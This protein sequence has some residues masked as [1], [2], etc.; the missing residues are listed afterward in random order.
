ML[1]RSDEEGCGAVV[2]AAHFSITLD[3][4][5]AWERFYGPKA[6]QSSDQIIRTIVL[7]EDETETAV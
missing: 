7:A 5:E 3:A 1:T 4:F 2:A 6:F